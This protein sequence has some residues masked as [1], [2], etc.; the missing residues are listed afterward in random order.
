MTR[1]SNDRYMFYVRDGSLINRKPLQAATRF[2]N[3]GR[4]RFFTG[5]IL[6]ANDSETDWLNGSIRRLIFS[7]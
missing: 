5:H 6:G 3:T 1:G 2:N 7:Q 4:D